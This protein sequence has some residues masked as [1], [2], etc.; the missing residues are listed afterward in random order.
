[1]VAATEVSVFQLRDMSAAPITTTQQK[2]SMSLVPETKQNAHQNPVNT[3]DYSK[4][5]GKDKEKGHCAVPRAF[6]IRK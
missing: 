6:Q 1:M 3:Q 5:I 4:E 2:R